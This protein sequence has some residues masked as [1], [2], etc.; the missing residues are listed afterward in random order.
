[1]KEPDSYSRAFCRDESLP[2][3]KGNCI[4]V[5]EV[6]VRVRIFLSVS[7]GHTRDQSSALFSLLFA[8]GRA[9]EV[10]WAPILRGCRMGEV[11]GR[12]LF[13]RAPEMFS[14]VKYLCR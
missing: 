5:G 7:A 9:A 10:C 1:M 13:C 14:E 2:A 6:K 3:A 11:D 12:W 8:V 4:A